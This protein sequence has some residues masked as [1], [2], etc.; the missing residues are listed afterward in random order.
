MWE[1]DV[2]YNNHK[3]T[4]LDIAVL[5]FGRLSGKVDS[6]LDS[7]VNEALDEGRWHRR[8][9]TVFFSY[10]E[11]YCVIAVEATPRLDSIF[12]V[13]TGT[14]LTGGFITRRVS[15]GTA[16]RVAKTCWY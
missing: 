15:R 2:D 4:K 10:Y 11:E 6:L 12:N 1:G 3:Y 5:R 13:G 7:L 8:G 9:S 14:A 16:I